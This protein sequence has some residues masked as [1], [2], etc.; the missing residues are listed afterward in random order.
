MVAQAS[1][2]FSHCRNCKETAKRKKTLQIKASRDKNNSQR[3]NNISPN[4]FILPRLNK[5][6]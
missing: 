3:I 6:L 1:C 5:P 2:C 4:R